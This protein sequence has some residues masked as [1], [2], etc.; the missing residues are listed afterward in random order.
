LFVHK[1]VQHVF[2]MPMFGAKVAV[3]TVTITC[4]VLPQ[5]REK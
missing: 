4:V 5:L 1:L 2:S 3:F